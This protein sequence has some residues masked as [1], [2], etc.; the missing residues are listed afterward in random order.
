MTPK[1][2]AAQWVNATVRFEVNVF[3]FEMKAIDKAH[4]VFLGSFDKLRFNSQ[5]APRWPKRK[6]NYIHPMLQET[7]NLKSSIEKA[8]DNG[9]VSKSPN[10]SAELEVGVNAAILANS[11]RQYGRGFNYALVH[12]DGIDKNVPPRQFI[13]HSSIMDTFFRNVAP[14]IIF[15]GFPR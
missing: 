6:R 9:F 13:G 3:N 1:Q 14:E 2:F 7:G 8:G 11:K 5:S 10:G 12:N 15:K 4:N